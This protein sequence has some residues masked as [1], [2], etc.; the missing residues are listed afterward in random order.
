MKWARVRKVLGV[1]CV[2]GYAWNAET[3][4]NLDS[5]GIATTWHEAYEAACEWVRS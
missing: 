5:F 2:Y 1:W 3:F 4:D